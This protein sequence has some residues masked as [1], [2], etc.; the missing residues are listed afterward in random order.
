[1]KLFA[2]K[3]ADAFIKT[4]AKEFRYDREIRLTPGAKDTFS[5][6]GVKVVFDA[7]GSQGGGAQPAGAPR[8]DASADV[9]L[10]NSP[11]AKSLKEQ[12]AISAIASGCGSIAT[13]TAATSPRDL[14]RTVSS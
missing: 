5:E 11:E 4:G 2:K 8:A 1:M 14:G 12:S 7:G 9:K 3:D 10:F 13:A 6:A